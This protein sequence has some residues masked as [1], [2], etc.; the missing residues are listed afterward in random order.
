MRIHPEKTQ[1]EEFNILGIAGYTGTLNDRQF[2][3]LR[4]LGYDGSLAD[5]FARLELV[6]EDFRTSSSGVFFTSNEFELRVIE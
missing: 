4:S 5:M 3:Y 1:D 2:K 6:Y